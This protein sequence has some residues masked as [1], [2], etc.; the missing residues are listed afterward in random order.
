VTVLLVEVTVTDPPDP[1]VDSWLAVKVTMWL[2]AE[3]VD[4]GY[5]VSA[6]CS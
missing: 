5:V 4:D 3:S 6:G 1:S 2:W